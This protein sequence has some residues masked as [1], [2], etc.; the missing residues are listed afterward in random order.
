MSKVGILPVPGDETLEFDGFSKLQIRIIVV[1]TVTSVLATIGLILRFY[2]RTCLM[3]RRLA[4]DDFLLFASWAVYLSSFVIILTVFPCGYGKHLWNVTEELLQCYIKK[5]LSIA[6]TYFWPPTLAKL[7]LIVLYYR[8]SLNTGFRVALYV[9]AF[10]ITTYTIAFTAI[11]SGPCKPLNVDID[12][13]LNDITLAQA[14]L[15]ISTDGVLVLMPVV[16][17]WG[18]NMPRRQKVSVCCILALASGVAVI[19]SCA[20]IACIRA[21]IGNQDVLYRQGLGAVWSAVEVNIGILCN[22]LATLKPFVQRHLPWLVSLVGSDESSSSEEGKAKD[23]T[24]RFGRFVRSGR[25]SGGS[26]T[27]AGNYQLHSFGRDKEACMFGEADGRSTTVTSCI[28][29]LK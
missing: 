24:A 21:M 22:C 8:I 17:L 2:T 9:I 1:N 13:C 27:G 14:V 16:M 11:I 28:D 7:S 15:N 26:A 18:L 29:T 20:R 6:L 3:Q 12:T 5:R 23:S 10:V 25:K 19:A 4:L